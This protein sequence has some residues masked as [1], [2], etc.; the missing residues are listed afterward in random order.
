MRKYLLIGLGLLFAAS[1]ALAQTGGLGAISTWPGAFSSGGFLDF[2]GGP[3]SSVIR[4]TGGTFTANGASSVTVTN[5]NVTA[6]SVVV[7]GLK[8][9]GGT[10]SGAPYMFT[11]TP[12]TGFTVRAGASDTSA[13]NYWILG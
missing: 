10:I 5:S 13:Y 3:Q 9:A 11:V 7:F 2:R 4:A 1:A 12:A 8:T 6:N